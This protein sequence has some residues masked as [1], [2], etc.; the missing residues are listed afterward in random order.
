MYKPCKYW[1][2]LQTSTGAGFL[3]RQQDVTFTECFIMTIQ[4]TFQTPRRF[5]G[6]PVSKLAFFDVGSS[7][8]FRLSRFLF[9]LDKEGLNVVYIYIWTNILHIYIYI[10]IYFSPESPENH[11][12]FH[13]CVDSPQLFFFKGF[14]R[15]KFPTPFWCVQFFLGVG[16]LGRNGRQAMSVPSISSAPSWT[17]GTSPNKTWRCRG[18][19]G[20]S[21]K[22]LNI[23]LKY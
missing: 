5:V 12:F 7:P 9:F 4:D 14:L 13:V 8:S 10:Y 22:G 2:R 11:Y 6:F 23:G 19:R 1:D 21:V 20:F 16:L 3:N 17:N 15:W 18:L